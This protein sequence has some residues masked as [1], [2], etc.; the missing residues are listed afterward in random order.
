MDKKQ[1]FVFD[2]EAEMNLLPWSE[3]FKGLIAYVKDI[4]RY[5][6]IGED[7]GV[8]R[9]LLNEDGQIFTVSNFVNVTLFHSLNT[10]RIMVVCMDK[11][12]GEHFQFA[13]KTGDGVTSSFRASESVTIM[14]EFPVMRDITILVTQI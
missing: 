9:K 13:W 4:D 6:R 10:E 2:T 1:Y 3:R 5:F 12:T 7:L 14:S 8:F 11:Q